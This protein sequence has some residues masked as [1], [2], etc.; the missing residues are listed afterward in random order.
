[1]NDNRV[2]LCEVSLFVHPV[3]CW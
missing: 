3:C 2:R 1:M